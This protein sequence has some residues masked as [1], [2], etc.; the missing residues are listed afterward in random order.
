M[1]KVM[2]RIL[3]GLVII[4]SCTSGNGSVEVENG[5]NISGTVG[6]P[7]TGDILIEEY[8]GNKPQPF[9]TLK[10]D[11]NYKYSKN[12]NIER[13]G[14]YR[15]NFYN[16]QF[17][18][19]ILNEDDVVVNVD[20]NERG[21]FVEISGSKDHDFIEMVQKMNA[22]FQASPQV[23]EINNRFGLANS[24]QDA[25]AIATI[26]DEYMKLDH[27]FKQK[28]AAKI[29]SAGAS[30]GVI[31]ILKSG[32]F[33]DK[34]KFQATYHRIAEDASTKLTNS[35]VAMDFVNEVEANKNLAIGMVAPDIAL[36]NPDGEVIALS[37]LRGKYVLV[38]FWA[39]WCGPCRKENPNVVK[40]YN[41]FN[42]KGFEVYGVSLDRRKEDWLQAI[43]QDGLHWTQVSDLKYW[44]SEAAKIYNIKAIPFALLLDPDGVIIGK[45][46]RGRELE[47]KLEEIFGES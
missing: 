41:R 4:T 18:N 25:A 46:L 10:L 32:R 40:A 36:P 12:V 39:K 16:K 14:Y 45:N 2:F 22:E 33:L 3:L 27:E 9:D 8:V 28:I 1:T 42:D 24:Q 19:L 31:E 37:S 11:E 44:N 38:D 26:R 20:G 7:Q 5:I 29:D 34:D 13:P 23:A 21:G 15:L 43:E 6:F 35:T 30:L 17:V 47:R